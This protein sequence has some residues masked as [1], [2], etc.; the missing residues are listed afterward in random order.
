MVTCIN[1]SA[2]AAAVEA[3][4]HGDNDPVVFREAYR[5]RRDY[6]VGR[7]RKMG[8]EMAVPEGAFYV[9]AKIPK[10]FGTDDFAFALRLAKEGRLG[11]ILIR[12]WKRR[13]RIR[14]NFLCG[15]R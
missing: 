7:M 6:M 14:K 1:D 8:F 4:N 11:I 2:Q 3:L 5:H 15:I 10:E 9:F 12:L 13:R